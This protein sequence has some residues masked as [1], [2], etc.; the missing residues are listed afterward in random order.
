MNEDKQVRATADS[1][2]E[3]RA[4]IQE[5]VP[6]G[7]SVISEKILSDGKPQVIEALGD[8]VDAAFQR[9]LSKKPDGADVSDQRTVAEPQTRAVTIEAFE[10]AVARE[11]GQTRLS[12]NGKVLKVSM[13][14]TGRRGFLGI[15]K[16]PHTYEVELWEPAKVEITVKSNAV[17]EATVGVHRQA[18][19]KFSE[20]VR[21]PKGVPDTERRSTMRFQFLFSGP[22]QADRIISSLPVNLRSALPSPHLEEY[23]PRSMPDIGGKY[24]VWYEDVS[25]T[26]GEGKELMNRVVEAGGEIYEAFLD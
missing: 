7:M 16:K 12:E 13:K 8:S 15:G 11:Q 6:E 2:E 1:I 25:L 3:A 19:E 18:W 24:N 22:S 5:Q 10:E 9:A 21:V 20:Y 14:T 4:K 26:I 17:I 23:V